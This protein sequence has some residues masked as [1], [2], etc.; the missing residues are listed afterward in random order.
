MKSLQL[1]APHLIAMVGAPGAGKTHFANEFAKMFGAARLDSGVL[2][3]LSNDEAAIRATSLKLLEQMLTTRQTIIFEGATEKRAWRSEIIRLARAAGYK[4]LFVWVQT[5]QITARTR[6]VRLHRQSEELFDEYFRQFSPP[7]PS[8]PYVVISGRH[9]Y[10][11]QARTVLK[12]L[13]ESARPKTEPTI[14]PRRT[15]MIRVN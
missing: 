13:S 14:Q 15:N 7:H 6:W 9:T 11:T 3:D 1:S 10:N 12:R 2:K 4:V 5:D 8:E